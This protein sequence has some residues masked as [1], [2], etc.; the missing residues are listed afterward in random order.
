VTFA[1]AQPPQDRLR[2]KFAGPRLI[3]DLT[4]GAKETE[5][6][7]KRR[8][9]IPLES[10]IRGHGVHHVPS[11]PSRRRCSAPFCM[12]H[13]AGRKFLHWQAGMNAS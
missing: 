13:C 2:D 4:F 11:T 12:T 1:I 3:G 10:L 5:R 6:D 8:F 9:D 7:L